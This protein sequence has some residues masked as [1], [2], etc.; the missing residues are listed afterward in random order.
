MPQ[1]PEVHAKLELDDLASEALKKIREGFEGVNDKVKEVGHEMVSMARQAAA[2]ALGFQLS[3]MVDS[4]KELAGEAFHGATEMENER[5]ELAGLIMLTDK[6]GASFDE[7]QAR[8]GELNERL[9]DM[10]TRAGVTKAQMVDAFEMIAQRSTRGTEAVA[11]MTEKMAMASRMLPGGMARM[12]EGWRD[13]EMGFI[14]PKNAMIML[15]KQAG[16]IE[17]PLRVA[18][19][20]LNALMQT[21]PGKEKVF[22]MAEAA[23]TKMAEKTK[24]MPPTFEQMTASL[25]N[26]REAM[27]ESMG[28]PMV[29]AI[30]GPLTRLRGYLETHREEIEKLAHTMGERVGQWM[31][32]AAEK[33]QEGFQYLKDH[34]DDILGALEKGAHALKDALEFMIRHKELIAGLML[35]NKLGPGAGGAAASMVGALPGMGLAAGR[36]VGSAASWA[37]A[38]GT[39]E[40]LPLPALVAVVAWA[41]AAKQAML[42]EKEAGISFTTGL[43]HFVGGIIGTTTNMADTSNKM[44]N[45][46]TA[47]RA[48][49]AAMSEGA[50]ADKIEELALK[51]DSLGR[52]AMSTGEVTADAINEMTAAAHRLAAED[53]RKAWVEHAEQAKAQFAHFDGQTSRYLQSV[54]GLVEAHK[55]TPDQILKTAEQIFAANE[56][57]RAGLAGTGASVSDAMTAFRKAMGFGEGATPPQM[58]LSGGGPVHIEIKQ[59]FRDQDPDRIALIFRRDLQRAAHTSLQAKTA[60]PLGL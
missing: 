11:D 40:A 41:G 6:G 46:Q 51:V 33:I 28:T 36:A 52:A 32:E 25:H 22:A 37:T 38:A 14:R 12:A 45:L 42:F 23:I 13:L 26:I 56:S 57:L 15:M 24:D 8:A 31:T 9:E 54:K 49:N 47:Q 7:A 2:V 1:D 10:G 20:H 35:A 27:F 60:L 21:E 58:S 4:F 59:D 44:L 55:R 50:P 53:A 5:K 17:G 48:L 30:M 16:V 19:K 43:S 39:A 3:G 34:A 18:A 29:S